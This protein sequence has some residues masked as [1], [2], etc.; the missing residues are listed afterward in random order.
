MADCNNADEMSRLARELRA[1]RGELE[2]AGNTYDPLGMAYSAV[3]ADETVRKDARKAV[4]GEIAAYV[5]DKAIERG[6]KETDEA[7]VKRMQE[8]ARMGLTVYEAHEL[9]ERACAALTLKEDG[10][11]FGQKLDAAV[12]AKI[13]PKRKAL[14]GPLETLPAGINDDM[15]AMRARMTEQY[16]GMLHEGKV[17]S[18][19]IPTPVREGL[20]D[21][22]EVNILRMFQRQVPPIDFKEYLE[23]LGDADSPE[24]KECVQVLGAAVADAKITVDGKQIQPAQGSNDAE[25]KQRGEAFA[26]VLIDAF[27]ERVETLEKDGERV[28]PDGYLAERSKDMPRLDLAGIAQREVSPEA[29]AALDRVIKNDSVD[30]LFG[31]M[32]RPGMRMRVNRTEGVKVGVSGE[33]SGVELSGSLGLTSADEFII[34][35]GEDGRYGVVVS[36]ALG[37]RLTA[38]A[39][40][41][42]V[43]SAE[44]EASL[45]ATRTQGV[46]FNF[47]NQEQCRRF[48]G[49][50]LAVEDLTPAQMM[51]HVQ[52]ISTIGAI[53]A[54]ASV[55]A[56]VKPGEFI[57]SITEKATQARNLAGS[58]IVPEGDRSA[59]SGKQIIDAHLAL[60][61]S[62]GGERTTERISPT[63][64]RITTRVKMEAGIEAEVSAT[65]TENL[66]AEAK[67]EASAIRQTS[68]EREYDGDVLTG[69]K[70]VRTF[71][72][73]ALEPAEDEDQAYRNKF[74]RVENVRKLM[75]EY[76]VVNDELLER[77][78]DMKDDEEF[79]F[80]ITSQMEQSALDRYEAEPS[81]VRRQAMLNDR[82]NYRTNG[83]VVRQDPRSVTQSREKEF[84]H[85]PE[86]D[87]NENEAENEPNV[88][89]DIRDT[90]V[91]GAPKVVKQA[92]DGI[93]GV[94][95]AVNGVINKIPVKL[96]ASISAETT[97]EATQT[98]TYRAR[99][100]AVGKFEMQ[101]PEARE[102]RLKEEAEAERLKA[103]AEKA[104]ADA[105]AKAEA[106]EE[107]KKKAAETK[108]ETESVEDAAA[109]AAA[110]ANADD[111]AA[112]EEAANAPPYASEVDPKTVDDLLRDCDF[113]KQGLIDHFGDVHEIASKFT[114]ATEAQQAKMS[115]EQLEGY[116]KLKAVADALK[117]INE[118]FSPDKDRSEYDALESDA[119][120]ADLF[121]RKLDEAAAHAR[122]GTQE[123]RLYPEI[124]NKDLEQ[125]IKDSGLDGQNISADAVKERLIGNF[126][127]V[128]GVVRGF[129][130]AAASQVKAMT[131]AQKEAY[132]KRK[133]LVDALKPL[134]AVFTDEAGRAEYDGMDPEAQK[135]R[136]DEK[137]NTAARQAAEGVGKFNNPR[138]Q[139]GAKGLNDEVRSNEPPKAQ[140]TRSGEPPKAPANERPA[141]TEHRTKVSLSDMQP[142]A[143]PN[144]PPQVKPKQDEKRR[145]SAM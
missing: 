85:E 104:E 129:Q 88:L 92:A 42:N 32:A 52:S 3:D 131:P 72:V 60:S 54:E 8:N 49:G 27:K 57:T 128:D 137:L 22:A 136:F 81:P 107:A 62:I 102:A 50:L 115:P 106:E 114:E 35:H 56:E 10:Q 34:T 100:V 64:K 130:E 145:I 99:D 103:E 71:K 97:G 138:T 143:R 31:A 36:G 82:G 67:Y 89:S 61:A 110:E 12:P 19:K 24:H 113:T 7:Y 28:G 87:S 9:H 63:R 70:S 117:P 111:A 93:Q 58:L 18:N 47:E 29:A 68:L 75:K 40:V 15:A 1:V 38:G 43:V 33:V 5:N 125:L 95:D 101:T 16:G 77:I 141:E 108:P 122:E 109:A 96:T 119:E 26:G 112:R 41:D 78:A 53:G 124:D 23:R 21:V 76:G 48:M 142:K 139:I 65:L 2:D 17:T 127:A 132:E 25:T 94:A 121:A 91:S 20:I 84:E 140:P 105:K 126:G 55:S 123:H 69:A 46:R 80:D 45:A 144:T 79:E 135:N 134:H 37:A 6:A 39:S 66:S 51:G 118:M 11:T 59:E 44:V 4:R 86:E 83:I 14:L 74:E 73:E 90:V 13:E 133:A 30:R 120:R 98:T 116:K